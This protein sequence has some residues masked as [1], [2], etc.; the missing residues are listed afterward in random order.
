MQ[1]YFGNI[2]HNS[3]PT[4]NPSNTQ[5]MFLILVFHI[6]IPN[7]VWIFKIRLTDVTFYLFDIRYKTYSAIIID[8]NL[9]NTNKYILNA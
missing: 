9:P 8:Q 1:F 6:F 2:K 5:G 4:V 7:K 3:R